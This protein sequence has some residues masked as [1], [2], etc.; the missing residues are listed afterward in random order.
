VCDGTHVLAALRASAA[1]LEGHRASVDALNVFPV[2]DGDTGTNM[3]L[4]LGAALRQAENAAPPTVGTVAEGAARGA[5]MG[6]RGNSGV[7]LSQLLH[8]FARAVRDQHHI[9]AAELAAGLSAAAEA[10][11]RSV[12]TPVEGTILTVATAAATAA[13]A[14][15]ER[16]HDLVAVL[17]AALEE[18]RAAVARTPEQLPILREARVVDAGAQGYLLVIEGAARYLHGLP[19]SVDQPTATDAALHMA[20]V[21]HGDDYGYCTEFA[22]VG[23]DLDLATIRDAVAQLGES[24]LVVGDEGLMHIHVHT[25]DPGRV[26]SYAAPLGRLHQVK[27]ESMQEQHDRFVAQAGAAAPRTA[28]GAP[29]GAVEA[30]RPPLVRQTAIPGRTGVVAVAPGEGLAAVFRS[31]GA[32]IVV[33]GGQTMN[34][35]TEELL[36]A[37]DTLPQHDVLLLPNNDNVLAAAAQARALSRKAVT[38]V[39]TRT[40]PQGTAALV[41][42]SPDRDAASNA[43]AMEEAAAGVRTAEITVAVRD[44]QLEGLAVRAGEVLGVLDGRPVCAGTDRDAVALDLLERMGARDADVL[45]L[46]YGRDVTEQEAHALARRVRERYGGPDVEVISGGQPHYPYIMSIE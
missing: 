21:A 23:P 27:I 16:G 1:W 44:A 20:H 8:G 19:V 15:A 43:A 46:Y 29:P 7:I 3:A 2:P 13:A 45:T 39:P 41:A 9:G 5:L 6:A 38:I 32:D 12:T 4:T 11:R 30:D 28:D 14:A 31:L 36:T 42:Y 33:P 26:L 40:V 22:V 24:T 34:P 18:T 10:A 17:D 37:I 35:S 25:A